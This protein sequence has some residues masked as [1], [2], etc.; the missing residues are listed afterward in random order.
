M[1]KYISSILIISLVGGIVNSL[2]DNF[3]DTKKYVNYFLSLIMVICMISPIASLLGNLSTIKENFYNYFDEL[4]NNESLNGNNEIIINTGTEAII[5]GIKNTIIENFDF[6]ENEIIVNL[7]TDT[8]NIE[9]IK[10]T[11]INVILT[12]KASWSD[13]DTVKKYLEN[14]VGGEI[15]VCRR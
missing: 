12:G 5:K 8:T 4:T 6:D 1:N 15:S 13:V 11:K 10:I 9:A 2:L 3:K 14:V 7:E